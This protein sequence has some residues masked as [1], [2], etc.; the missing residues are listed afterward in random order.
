[1]VFGSVARGVARPN[2]DLDVAIL[3]TV[4]RLTL[5]ASLSDAVGREVD[6]VEISAASIPML[7]AIVRDGVVAFERES[8]R[9]A[10][11]LS[12]S[13]TRLAVDLPWYERMQRTW[14]ER[15]ATRGL[16]GRS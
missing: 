11:F 4:D 2:S 16:L 12:Q 15:V 7:H 14:L 10:A 1:M 6:V 9:A 3:G 5:A 8:G 13:W